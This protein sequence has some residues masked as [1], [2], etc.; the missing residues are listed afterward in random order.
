MKNR[1]KYYILIILSIMVLSVCNNK[2][3]GKAA[4]NTDSKET[5]TEDSTVYDEIKKEEKISIVDAYEKIKDVKTSNG[6]IEK[7]INELKQLLGCEGQFIYTSD[8]T[9]HDYTAV[10]SFYL[11]KGTVFC[12]VDYTGFMGE[13]KDGPV[14]ETTEEGYLFESTTTG[15]LFSRE[16]DFKIYFSDNKVRITWGTNNDHLLERD[17]TERPE[18]S[19]ESNFSD[20]IAIGK[21]SV[22]GIYYDNKYIPLSENESLK[23]MYDGYSLILNANGSYSYYYHM[24]VD[25]G[26]WEEKTTDKLD[27]SIV[28]TRQSL[29]KLKKKDD[30]YEY[31][32]SQSSISTVANIDDK[33]HNILYLL[34]G[35]TMLLFARDTGNT[36]LNNSN[37]KENNSSLPESKDNDPNDYQSESTPNDKIATTGEKNALEKA[38]QYLNYSAFSYTGLIAQLE[39]EGFSHSEAQYAADN[40]GADWNEEAVKKA[41]QY[42]DYSSFSRESLIEQLV[43]EGFTQSQAE[44]GVSKAY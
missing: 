27:H 24:F 23:K 41:K 18:I 2:N 3:I 38:L 5:H 10:V 17:Q 30:G 31:E 20:S 25:E 19:G 11:N 7:F 1:I 44:Y 29:G 6:E 13:I 16:L 39:Y 21:W 43:F 40:C 15:D 14:N 22:A 12:K 36:S 33:N 9:K 35:K 32:K 34:D 37:G 28:L 42:L 8:K 26:V 4:Q